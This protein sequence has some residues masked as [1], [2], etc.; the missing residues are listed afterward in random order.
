MAHLNFRQDLVL[1][2][3]GEKSV[4]TFLESKDAV[5]LNDNHD[6]K[7]DLA[8]EIKG[9]RVTYEIKTDVFCTPAKDTG[10]LFIEYKCR[11]KASGIEV[12]KADW[13]VTYYKHL[14]EMWFIKT[15]DLIDLIHNNKFREIV[16]GGDIGSQTHGY[17]I[18]R[19]QYKD[20]FKV[21]KYE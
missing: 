8:M 19:K 20:N 1:G 5:Y 12:T 4:R 18:N 7:Y 17:L 13:F 2:N 3:K 6:N 15:T 10:N 9:K 14:N 16:N 21:F 11:G